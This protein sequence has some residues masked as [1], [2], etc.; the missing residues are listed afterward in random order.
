MEDSPDKYETPL[1]I[2]LDE[3]RLESLRLEFA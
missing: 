2:N 1:D 3:A